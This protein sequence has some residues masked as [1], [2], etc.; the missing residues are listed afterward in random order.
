MQSPASAS[1]WLY[2]DFSSRCL[3]VV[4]SPFQAQHLPSSPFAAEFLLSHPPH[5]PFSS[6]WKLALLHA[7]SSVFSS[8]IISTESYE[9]I[10]YSIHHRMPFV[11]NDRMLCC[12]SLTVLKSVLMRDFPCSPLEVK[13][14]TLR[15][16]FQFIPSLQESSPFPSYLLSLLLMSLCLCLL[17]V[18]SAFKH[19]QEIASLEALS[20]ENSC[21]LSLLSSQ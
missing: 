16:L 7:V 10:M 21:L 17:N 20:H 2:P 19:T 3:L 5:L 14:I 13:G 4:C 11:A 8:R 15:I 12:I 9:F 6:G 1:E 18:S